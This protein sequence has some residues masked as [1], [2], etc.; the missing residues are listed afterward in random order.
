MLIYAEQYEARFSMVELLDDPKA[1]SVFL[2]VCA[3]EVMS[4]NQHLVPDL[5]IYVETL[6]TSSADSKSGHARYQNAYC[7]K[8]VRPPS[9]ILTL[10]EHVSAL[11]PSIPTTLKYEVLIL[12]ISSLAAKDGPISPTHPP[13]SQQLSPSSL[14]ISCPCV[15]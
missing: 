8:P 2:H 1:P 6:H 5:E 12:Q 4:D 7:I 9:S 14:P 10:S 15:T 3:F 13:K 11:H